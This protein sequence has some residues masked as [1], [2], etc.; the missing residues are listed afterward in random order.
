MLDFA[1]LPPE[2]NSALMYPGQGSAPMLTAA[3][4]WA[5]LSADLHIMASSYEW[6]IAALTDGSWLGPASAP[7][8]R[9]SPKRSAPVV[10]SPR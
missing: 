5:G 10:G 4:A 9:P 8:P 6:V 1:L 7:K 2:I 3:A